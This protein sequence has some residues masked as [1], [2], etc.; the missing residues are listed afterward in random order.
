MC[1]TIVA[2]TRC[3]CYKPQANKRL[4]KAFC[5]RHLAEALYSVQDFCSSPILIESRQCGR[6]V[7]G[8]V[9]TTTL[10]VS[11]R[12][13]SHPGYVVVSLD[14]ALYDDYPSL[15]LEKA[16]NLHGKKTNVNRNTRNT[17][18]DSFKIK[19]PPTLPSKR[20]VIL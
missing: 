17:V 1:P 14:K 5:L 15:G 8:V 7:K 16:V 18:N 4:L 9:F 11:S 13:N 6:E 20:K 2:Y 10:I 12:F 3:K 19:G